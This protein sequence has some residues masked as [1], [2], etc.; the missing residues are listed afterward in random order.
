MKSWYAVQTEPQREKVAERFLT[1]FGIRT[2]L[3]L[4]FDRYEDSLGRVTTREGLL[5]PRYIFIHHDL[6]S[7][8]QLW[9]LP[10]VS[11]LL[12][13][14][15]PPEVVPDAVVEALLARVHPDDGKIH[16]ESSSRSMFRKGQKLRITRG[17]YA[18]RIGLFVQGTKSRVVVL[19]DVFNRTVKASVEGDAVVAV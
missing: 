17:M 9:E 10:G 13:R 19:L 8:Q 12:P 1:L 14:E 15:Q 5:Y 7:H 2:F 3:P 16:S 6:R 18:D 4:S 11:T